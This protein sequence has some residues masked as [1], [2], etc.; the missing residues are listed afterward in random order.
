[1][2]D[3][4]SSLVSPPVLPATILPNHCYDSM[5]KGCINIGLV[6]NEPSEYLYTFALPTS[7]QGTTIG[8]DSLN[9]MFAN[10]A[11]TISTPVFNTLY[12]GVDKN[13]TFSFPFPLPSKNYIS[14][15][16]NLN[17]ENIM[18][19]WGDGSQ[20]PSQNYNSPIPALMSYVGRVNH[21]YRTSSVDYSGIITITGNVKYID[22]FAIFT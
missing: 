11:N 1:M 2:F 3:S 13:N 22:D 5:M 21:T 8:T 6:D 7:L 4:C 15:S 16:F 12:Y 20:S 14:V 17:G 9:L 18:I 19:D 10:S